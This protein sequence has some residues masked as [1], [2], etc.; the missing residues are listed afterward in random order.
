MGNLLKFDLNKISKL[1]NSHFFVE[2]GTFEGDT[3]YYAYKSLVL[4]KESKIEKLWTIEYDKLYADA[5]Y[6]RFKNFEKIE[7]VNNDSIQGLKYVCANCNSNAIFW[8]DAHFIGADS[9]RVSYKN[10]ENLQ[11]RLPLEW[12][13][14]II[15]KRAEIYQDVIF[16]DDVRI[17]EDGPFENG[18]FD[19]A[20]K[21]S[22]SCVRRVDIS[23]YNTINDIIRPFSTTHDIY[24]IYDHQGYIIMLPKNKI[25][26]LAEILWS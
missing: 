24:K 25:Q 17:Y 19:D 11:T 13:L 15:H 23:P 10:D 9:G 1:C 7:V 16:I 3:A 26:T 2:T 4:D 22:N 6:R 14:Q 5:A 12:E 20:M 18:T 8:L 21:S